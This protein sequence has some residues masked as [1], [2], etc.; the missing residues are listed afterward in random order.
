MTWKLFP[1]LALMAACVSTKT[2]KELAEFREASE[3]ATIERGELT[4]RV[5]T[6]DKSIDSLRNVDRETA[7]IAAE[8]EKIGELQSENIR[9]SKSAAVDA[10]RAADEVRTLEKRMYSF[11]EEIQRMM[12]DFEKREEAHAKSA[13][14]PLR[15]IMGLLGEL[16]SRT[17][18]IE[19][20]LGQ[21]VVQQPAP[22]QSGGTAES[23]SDRG[24]H[25]HDWVSIARTIQ[26]LNELRQ[27][28][29]DSVSWGTH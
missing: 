28:F 2:T 20:Q 10:A 19:K 23:Q 1:I 13:V 17:T 18:T 14:T 25:A 4:G 15:D 9:L 3:K 12:S 26:R 8:V 11:H 29:H 7:R 5:D 21:A 16:N 22:A 27:E 6:Q 24:P